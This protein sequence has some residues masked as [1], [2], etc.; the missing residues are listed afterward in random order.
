[1][2]RWSEISINKEYERRDELNIE[3]NDYEE[4]DIL[5]YG[6]LEDL[7]ILNCMGVE[8]VYENVIWAE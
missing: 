7:T 6:I 4:Y 5:S 2:A 3:N 8:D 1:M